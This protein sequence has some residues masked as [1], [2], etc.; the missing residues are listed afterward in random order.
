MATSESD[1]GTITVVCGANPKRYDNLTG[2]TVAQV[3]KKLKDELNI[4]D[5]CRGNHFWRQRRQ[6][7]PI[8]IRR[9]FGICQAWQC[10]RKVK[11]KKKGK[12][13]GSF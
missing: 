2:Q 7:L 3:R 12:Q 9:R 1:K 4:P 6:Q 5:G 8:E 13:K 11:R 10:K